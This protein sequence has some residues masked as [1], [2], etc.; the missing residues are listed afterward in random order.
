MDRPINKKYE[1]V[2]EGSVIKIIYGDF[3]V[4]VTKNDFIKIA[5]CIMYASDKIK[6]Y[7]DA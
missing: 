1:V 5:C 3:M 6:Q 7:K 4:T 2:N